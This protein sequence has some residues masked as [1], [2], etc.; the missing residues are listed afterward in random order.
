MNKTLEFNRF[1]V[2]Y[3]DTC[4]H[5]A[6]FVGLSREMLKPVLMFCGTTPVLEQKIQI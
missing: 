2:C 6:I 4:L 3:K 1:S 5:L